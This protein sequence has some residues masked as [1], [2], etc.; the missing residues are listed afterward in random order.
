MDDEGKNILLLLFR[1]R[2]FY[3]F[4]GIGIGCSWF[5][6]RLF[7]RFECFFWVGYFF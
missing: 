3:R 1:V 4:R 5:K 2:I 6:N 7:D